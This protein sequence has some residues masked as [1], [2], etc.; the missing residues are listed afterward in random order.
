MQSLMKISLLTIYLIIK[1]LPSPAT[2]DLSEFDGVES[3]EKLKHIT[4]NRVKAP[5]RR[6]PSNHR[7]KEVIVWIV[8]KAN[9]N[10]FLNLLN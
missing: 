6:P 3:T 7:D 5:Q 9:V 1:T 10:V 4:A 8:Y 2:E